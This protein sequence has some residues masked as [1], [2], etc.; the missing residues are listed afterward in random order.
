MVF[1]TSI[2]IFFKFFITIIFFYLKENRVSRKKPIGV[3]HLL[4]HFVLSARRS[5]LYGKQV[6]VYELAEDIVTEC[7]TATLLFLRRLLDQKRT[8]E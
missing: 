4:R 5:K 2:I 8:D 1:L 3:W 6:I 7:V